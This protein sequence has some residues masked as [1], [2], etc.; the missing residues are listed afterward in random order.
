MLT[1]RF[2]PLK[3]PRGILL[4]AALAALLLAVAAIALIQPAQAQTEDTHE[5]VVLPH[6]ITDT[7]VKIKLARCEIMPDPDG[8]NDRCLIPDPDI[9]WDPQL[10]LLDSYYSLADS[11][12]RALDVWYGE[13]TVF[14]V[15]SATIHCQSNRGRNGRERSV[16]FTGLSPATTYDIR[17]LRGNHCETPLPTL[18]QIIE[19]DIGP[20]MPRT[21]DGGTTE[22]IEPTVTTTGDPLPDLTDSSVK[23]EPDATLR[24]FRLS[25]VGFR[26]A[27]QGWHEPWSMELTNAELNYRQ[28]D[29]GRGSTRR[30]RVA[31]F[32]GLRQ[33]GRT[34]ELRA[35]AG[36]CEPN[37]DQDTALI[38]KYIKNELDEYE[39]IQVTDIQPLKVEAF[40]DQVTH[41]SV[42]LRLSNDDAVYEPLA[43]PLHM[44]KWWYMVYEDGADVDDP[45]A[46]AGAPDIE[47]RSCS[48]ASGQHWVITGLHTQ[49]RGMHVELYRDAACEHRIIASPEFNLIVLP[50]LSLGTRTNNSVTVNI[51]TPHSGYHIK[52]AR[53]GCRPAADTRTFNNLEPTRR[54][55]VTLWNTPNCKSDSGY[56]RILGIPKAAGAD[57]GPQLSMESRDRDSI[58]IK[59]NYLDGIEAGTR[60]FFSAEER[61][62]GSPREVRVFCDELTPPDYTAE[63]DNLKPGTNYVFAL[64]LYSLER[65]DNANQAVGPCTSVY[66]DRQIFSTN[67]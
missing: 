36:L 24:V 53:T 43:G 37:R 65:Q 12:V 48:E 47:I 21:D 61:V 2:T 33:P 1:K 10:A 50:S 45:D 66:V 63:V 5:A 52:G 34:Y 58:E 16:Q 3:V 49:G 59:A 44:G 64:Y 9:A 55:I 67:P 13:F 23:P 17:L 6:K 42:R 51:S 7:S 31:R 27:I 38:V 39:G 40:I 14:L 25:P 8:G 57:G 18:A 20:I 35:Y 28:C 4:A 56:L 60:V 19:D 41:N 26:V 32:D 11:P 30:Q 22:I 62:G 54:Y 15:E 29:D 46:D